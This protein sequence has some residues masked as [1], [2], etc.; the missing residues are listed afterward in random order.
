MR[1][2]AIRFFRNTYALDFTDVEPDEQR[3]RILGNATF[4][5]VV[6]PTND[7]YVFNSWVVNGKTRTRCFRSRK[8]HFQAVLNGT[9]M[10]HGEYGGEEGRLA[11]A[12]DVLFYG[13]AVNMF[14]M[15]VNSKE[16]SSNWS[17]LHQF[18]SRNLRA[19]LLSITEFTIACLEKECFGGF[20]DLLL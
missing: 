9:V 16:L 17:Q 6:L 15:F 7:T 8:G 13:S 14:M 1:E 11:F 5:P 12:G 3:Q 18:V 10:L 4:Y 2:A 19:C 20:T